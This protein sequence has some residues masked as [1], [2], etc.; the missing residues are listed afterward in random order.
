MIR[1]IT[2]MALLT[3]CATPDRWSAESHREQ[4]MQCRVSCGETSMA[5]YDAWTGRCVCSKTPLKS[6][7]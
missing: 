2:I 5:S 1:A 7:D 4:M 6:D 3:G